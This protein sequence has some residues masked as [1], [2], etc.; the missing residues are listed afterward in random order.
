MNFKNRR[1]TKK[2]EHGQLVKQV[3]Q[4]L[5]LAGWRTVG[6]RAGAFSERGIW[7]IYADKKFTDYQF[8]G[9]K[10]LWVEVKTGK[11]KLSPEQIKFGSDRNASGVMTCIVYRLE[12]LEGM[13][14]LS[15]R[16]KL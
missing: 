9:T 14:I 11:D 5:E 4:V 12:D 1:S 10:A 6:I 2:Q 15:K 7:D 16:V 8:M 3:R 13:G